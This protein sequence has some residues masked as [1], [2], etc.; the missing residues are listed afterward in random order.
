[1]ETCAAIY[2]FNSI[3]MNC[4]ILIKIK[5]EILFYLWII[6]AKGR[7]PFRSAHSSAILLTF[8]VTSDCSTMKSLQSSVFPSTDIFSQKCHLSRRARL[9]LNANFTEIRI[10]G[11]V[12]GF[13]VCILIIH[14][15]CKLLNGKY[16]KMTIFQILFF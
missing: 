5:N 13:S 8:A 7:T 12:R 11:I 15:H 9:R 16:I 4:F 3:H 1:M 6:R 14:S 2:A 10:L